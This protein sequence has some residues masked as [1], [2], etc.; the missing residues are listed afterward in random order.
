M[1]LVVPHHDHDRQALGDR[2]R[3]L[4]PAHREAAVAA[5]RDDRALGPRQL[6]ADRAA[7]A[8]PHRAEAGHHEV[9]VG[10]AQ[11][12]EVRR[13][14]EVIARVDGVD[15]VGGQH[16]LQ[17]GERAGRRVEPADGGGA[18][19]PLEGWHGGARG[20]RRGAGGAPSSASS[21]VVTGA[22]TAWVAA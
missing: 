22:T 9:R 2:G 15:R 21:T 6:H 20:H 8:L 3:D 11:R 12:E 1:P 13:E 16:L 19:E 4:E 7:Q 10:V 17:L 18:V 14:Q 5:D